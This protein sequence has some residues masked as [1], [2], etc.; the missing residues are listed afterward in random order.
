MAPAAMTQAMVISIIKKGISTS[1]R[2]RLILKEMELLLHP[3]PSFR[4]I[5]PLP[6]AF[7]ISFISPCCFYKIM[8]PFHHYTIAP[9]KGKPKGLP[10]DMVSAIM[11]L[12]YAS[13]AAR[14]SPSSL[15]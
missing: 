6:S 8:T 1:K 4:L 9:K 2:L 15:H 3:L 13:A 12:H 10:K 7:S 14:A 11:I 5:L